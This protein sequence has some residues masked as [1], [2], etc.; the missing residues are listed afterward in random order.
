[1]S[2]VVSSNKV[3]LD[4]K[5]LEWEGEDQELKATRKKKPKGVKRVKLNTHNMSIKR[6]KKSVNHLFKN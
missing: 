3:D 6:S 5:L 1:M 2:R 4:D